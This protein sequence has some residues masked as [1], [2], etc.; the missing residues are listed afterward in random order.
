MV[1]KNEMFDIINTTLQDFPWPSA[2]DMLTSF[3][4]ESE[5]DAI[6]CAKFMKEHYTSEE[7]LA[8]IDEHLKQLKWCAK[9]FG[10]QNG[11]GTNKL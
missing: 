4:I 10:N 11:K 6:V 1:I 2:A 3:C 5:G 9:L 7:I 8:G